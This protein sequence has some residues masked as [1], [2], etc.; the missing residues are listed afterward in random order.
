MR[1]LVRHVCLSTCLYVARNA[2]LVIAAATAAMNYNQL[3]HFATLVDC[4]TSVPP[5]PR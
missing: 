2:L 4:A 1:K 3:G 5:L